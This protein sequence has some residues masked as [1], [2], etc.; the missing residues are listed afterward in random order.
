MS[1]EN[2]A[3]IS[4]DQSS[5]RPNFIGRY[6]RPNI[7]QAAMI[8]IFIVLL[9]IFTIINGFNFLTPRNLSNLFMQSTIT[10]ILAI[11]LVL[12]IVTGHIDLSVG[13]VLGFTGAISAVLMVEFNW[14]VIPSII[15][16]LVIGFLIGTWHGFWIAIQ[17]MPAVIVTL[18]SM[19]AFRGATILIISGKTLSIGGAKDPQQVAAFTA[20]GQAYIPKISDNL[21]F[22]DTSLYAVLATIALYII[23]DFVRRSNRIKYGF[24]VLPTALYVLKVF[25]ITVAI[26]A[27]GSIMIMNRGFNGDPLLGS[28]GISYKI[29]IVVILALI[30]TFIASNTTL[31][32]HLYAIGGNPEA[33]RLS[34]INIK[35]RTMI[36]FMIMG[37]L[38]AIAGIVYTSRLNAATISAGSGAELDAIASAV[39]GGTSLMGGEGTIIGAV[40]G[41]LVIST[42]DNGMNL[43]VIDANYQYIVKGL[44]LLMAVWLDFSR[45]KKV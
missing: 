19:L 28:S 27:V 14:G 22:N 12:V 21:P 33:A 3:P 23:L 34:G 30:F 37:L 42:L 24:N 17:R 15:A 26:A 41:A 38:T 4:Q 2:Q 10:A 18:S 35:S 29:I 11:G 36:L 13:S 6:I 9:I 43:M 45:K 25:L 16:T 31:G 7:S 39:I 32:R 44:F 40:I 20:I 1:S 5:G 8:I